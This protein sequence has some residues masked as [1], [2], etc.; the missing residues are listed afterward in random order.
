MGGGA[1]AGE[2]LERREEVWVLG[3]SELGSGGRGL[4]GG[5]M[6]AKGEV[7]GIMRAGL[8]LQRRRGGPEG[9]GWAKG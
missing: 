8:R 2:F 3:C 7:A 1:I 4:S 5:R 9:G 6:I